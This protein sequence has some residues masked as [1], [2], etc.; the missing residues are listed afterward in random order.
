MLQNNGL[1]LNNFNLNGNNSKNNRDNSNK[2]LKVSDE[3]KNIVNDKEI[4]TK[5][6]SK[7]K[8]ENLVYVKA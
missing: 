5:Q 7:N 8:S 2:D 1:N 4:D 6:D 3:E